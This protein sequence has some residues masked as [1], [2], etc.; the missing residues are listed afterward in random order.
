MLVKYV[1]PERGGPLSPVCALPSSPRGGE[2]RG[3]VRL[4]VGKATAN[5][6]LQKR[7]TTKLGKE[8]K[9]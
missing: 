1:V 3:R 2:P 7:L 5:K 6:T 4:F 8:E 9:P